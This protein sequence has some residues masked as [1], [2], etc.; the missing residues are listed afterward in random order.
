MKKVLFT[1]LAVVLAVG[2]SLP[3]ATPV[4]A[5]IVGLWHLD[6]GSGTT[7]NDRAFDFRNGIDARWRSQ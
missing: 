2:L 5:D 4:E 1:T 7:A 6:E 3:M